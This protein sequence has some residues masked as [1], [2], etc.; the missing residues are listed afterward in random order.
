MGPFGGNTNA[1]AS[2][3]SP[4]GGGGGPSPFGSGGGQSPFG[5]GAGPTPSSKPAKKPKKKKSSQLT[6]V[7]I[8]DDSGDKF[9]KEIT[10]VIQNEL[11][12]VKQNEDNLETSSKPVKKRR[13]SIMVSSTFIQITLPN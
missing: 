7:R 10:D 8:P 5:G 3:Q 2:G 1:G 9:V 6:S 13:L 4:F 12:Q 11:V